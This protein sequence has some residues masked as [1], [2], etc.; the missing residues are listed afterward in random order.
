[1]KKQDYI[2]AGRDV[3]DR[4]IEIF[5]ELTT[6]EL[7]EEQKSVIIN[8]EKIYR[9]Q[10]DVVAVHFHPEIVGLDLIEKRVSGMFPDMK[11]EFLI[12]TQHNIINT[13]KGYCGVEVDCYSPEFNRKVQLLVHFKE[14]RLKNASMFKSML[15]HTFK[16]RSSQFFMLMDTVINEKYKSSLDLARRECAA[17]DNLVKFVKLY[18][19]KFKEIVEDRYSQTDRTVIKNK[20][21]P[22]YFQRLKKYFDPHEIDKAIVFLK[23]VKKVVKRNFKLDFF[24]QTNEIIEEA[25]ALQAGILIPHPEQFWPVLL[26]DYDIDGIEV[27]NPQSRE[28]TEFLINV[29]VNK[30]NNK[31]FKNKP[32]LIF[33]GDDTHM[34]EKLKK[35]EDQDPFKAGREIGYQ[36]PWDDI[37]IRKSLIRGNFSRINMI[38]EYKARLS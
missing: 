18:T 31:V 15:E 36:P 21:L 1:M 12:P 14:N 6:T 25:R 11:N 22:N 28:F 23:E 17:D 34:G 38:N 9:N 32:F 37:V 7:T 16:Y 19:E 33:M 29:V 2:S 10:A 8:P 27:W 24:Y 4:D 26:A 30:N 5:K 20:L 35:K 3:T 13:Y